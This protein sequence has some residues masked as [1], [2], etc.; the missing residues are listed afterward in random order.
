MSVDNF[1]I[2][3]LWVQFCLSRCNGPWRSFELKYLWA[4]IGLRWGPTPNVQSLLQAI[5]EE[6]PWRYFHFWLIFGHAKTLLFGTPIS[7]PHCGQLAAPY[8]Y[9]HGKPGPNSEC[10]T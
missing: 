2:L 5:M 7:A 10:Y 1:A 9:A 6:Y 3:A 4:H 8:L